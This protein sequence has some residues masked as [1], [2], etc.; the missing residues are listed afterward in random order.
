[1]RSFSPHYYLW[2]VV[3]SVFLRINVF[4][5]NPPADLPYPKLI[6]GIS[7][8][9]L[10]NW[11]DAKTDKGKTE[12]IW[13]PFETP[14]YQISDTELVH[15]KAMGFDFLRVTV[16]PSIFLAHS[17]SADSP[18][19]KHLIQVSKTTIQRLIDAGFSVLFDLHPV[20]VNPDY[21]PLKLVESINSPTFKAYA[22]LVEVLAGSFAQLDANRFAFELMNEP[23][24]DTQEEVAR[25]QAMMELLHTRARKGSATLPLVL[26]G[27][28]WGDRKALM[29]LDLKP[30]KNS[31][32]LYTFHY[33]DP[34][35]FTH[36]GV[37]GDEAEFLAGLN[38]SISQDNLKK[39]REQAYRR[40]EGTKNSSKEIKQIKDVTTKLLKDYELTAHDQTRVRSDFEALSKWATS[41]GI[42]VQR[43]FLGEFGCVASA[44]KVPVG[45][46][47][48]VWLRSIRETAEAF[49]F[50]WAL[51][52]YKGYGGMGLIEG[53]KVDKGI[54]A[55]LNLSE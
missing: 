47:H 41:E 36:Q 31:N 30:F 54:A 16:D 18:K 20:G 12:Y 26:T 42:P 23:W 34:H 52:A 35:T 1:M 11:P 43:I 27:A 22:D 51:W 48:S 50:P 46:S 44:H 19:R 8:H 53:G 37:E 21:A 15:L 45:A 28:Q 49:G 24:L 10:L 55:G 39:V 2:S 14:E 6:K 33:Y 3:V 13:P 40:I 38:W 4:A 7:L 29:R 32:V 9:H 25:W 17:A 5:Q